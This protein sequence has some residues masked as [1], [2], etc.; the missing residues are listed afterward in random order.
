VARYDSNAGSITFRDE[1]WA[2][3]FWGEQIFNSFEVGP[4][5]LNLTESVLSPPAFQASIHASPKHLISPVFS[6]TGGV[7]GEATLRGYAGHVGAT[8]TF[9]GRWFEITFSSSAFRNRNWRCVMFSAG[10]KRPHFALGGWH[11]LKR[12]RSS[13]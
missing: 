7:T 6:E 10:L 13:R 2:P 4:S 9:N 8:G 3:G 11:T 12:K 1:V 5:C